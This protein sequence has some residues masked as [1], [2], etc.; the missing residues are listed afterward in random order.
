[1]HISGSVLTEYRKCDNEKSNGHW[2][3]KEAFQKLK[4][5]KKKTSLETKLDVYGL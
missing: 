3:A 5:E 1:M 2:T 4:K